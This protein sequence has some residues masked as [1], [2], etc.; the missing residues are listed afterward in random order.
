MTL[1]TWAFAS[2]SVLAAATAAHAVG[3]RY[4]SLDSASVLSD[5]KLEGTAVLSTGSV[6]ASVQTRRI[7][8]DSTQI[9]RSVLVLK[10]GSAFIGTGN[11]GKIWKLTG[12]VAKVI[13]ETDALV[14]SAL[15]LDAAGT[16]YAG[17]LPKGKVFA[18]DNAA[19]AGAQAPVKARELI[20][21]PGAEHVAAFALDAKKKL[22]Y[23]ATGPEGKV[24]AI[25]LGGKAAQ[26]KADV[27]YDSDA[28]HIM[29]LAL[30]DDGTLYAGT[31]DE[32]LLVK[33]TSPSKAEVVFDFEGNEIT[34]LAIQGTQLAVAANNFPKPTSP[35]KKPDVKDDKKSEDKT[36]APKDEQK[37]GKG[38]LW[39]VTPGARSRK[40]FT[41]DQGHLTAV[42]W[43]DASSGA[44][45]AATGKEGQIHRVQADG[46]SALWI[47]VDERQ[48]L[49][50]DLRA[51]H[52]VF[53]TADAGA[54]YRVLPKGGDSL[55]TSK[56]LD[57]QFLSRFGELSF[58]GRGALR[59]QTRSGNTDKP[60]ASWSEWS[61]E[62]DKPGP[63]RSPAARFLQIRA[64]LD[65]AKDPAS[66]LYAVTAYYL[67]LNQAGQVQEVT[68]KP[69]V[70]KEGASEPTS[71]YTLEWKVDN[72]D[73]D[74]LRY[75]LSFRP[76]GEPR[77]RSILRDSDVHTKTTYEWETE[78]IP[79]GYY[80]VAVEASDELESPADG[81]LKTTL[82]S[83]P[84]LVD[85][86]KPLVEGLKL[87]G[88][89][90]RGVARDL[91][92]PITKLERAIDNGDYEPFYPA[93]D[94][95]D[96]SQEPFALELPKLEPG[97]HVISIRATDARNNRGSAELWITVP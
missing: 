42:Q 72:P 47:D 74:K 38:Q 12:D 97:R 9:A 73:G 19:S 41:S 43:A 32:A 91:P 11:D 86:K 24:F 61:S 14:V 22:L 87:E 79:D 33:L 70:G 84:F 31:S 92:G 15:A 21:L 45:Y 57:A 49:A 7:A 34:A 65:I 1:R 27:F 58:R 62:L 78:S 68:A 39:V 69:K 55:W 96:T 85:N 40:L 18:I 26:P 52:P 16:L 5:G 2:L 71:L 4:F 28:S 30:A 60:N 17:T 64:K 53:V 89:R 13:A 83:E 94:L 77:G 56:V 8:L 88:G 80:R 51:E 29:S 50:L 81:T 63:I 82:E 67:P 54:A 37:P 48:V 46:R 6:V 95:L 20:A 66:E 76:E 36:E 10:D 75:R 25:A 90:I 35:A 59:L 44:I 23:A 93:D 3:T